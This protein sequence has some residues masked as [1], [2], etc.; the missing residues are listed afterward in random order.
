M[1]KKILVGVDDSDTAARAAQTA[2]TLAEALGGELHVLSAYPKQEVTKLN[3]GSDEFFFSTEADAG[4]T[5]TGVIAG[6]RAQ[7]PTV[8]FYNHSPEGRPAEATLRV[9]QQIDADLIVVGNKR[10]QGIA[11]VLGSIAADVAQKAPCDVYIAH[12]HQQ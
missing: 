4:A 6:L 5:A 10:V 2:A 11:R 7:F 1:T 9:A 12:T 8:T 3:V